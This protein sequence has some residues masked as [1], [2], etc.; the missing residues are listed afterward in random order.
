MDQGAMGG[1]EC[2][3][4]CAAVPFLGVGYPA[5]SPLFIARIILPIL[6]LS[7]SL[8]P[9][10]GIVSP[11]SAFP[12]LPSDLNLRPTPTL[13]PSTLTPHFGGWVSTLDDAD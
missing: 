4:N 12:Y 6:P 5:I 2:P 1:R 8:S 10:T 9:E 7:T 13:A 11:P 3:R